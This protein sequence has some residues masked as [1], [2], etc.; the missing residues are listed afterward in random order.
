MSD[1]SAQTSIANGSTQPRRGCG[2]W[3]LIGAGAL[4]A[5]VAIGELAP[6][7]GK[8][9]PKTETINIGLAPARD[10]VSPEASRK[11]MGA[12]VY[13]AIYTFAIPMEATPAAVEQAAREQ[14]E[15]RTFCQVYGWVNPADKATAWPMLDREQKALAFRYALNRDENYEA[16]TWYCGSPG[17]QPKC[18]KP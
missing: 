14:C 1:D 3:A 12:V 7:P 17:A 13:N 15:G 9:P 10:D 4:A 11:A 5:F 2:F 6:D 18:E 8:A 16:L